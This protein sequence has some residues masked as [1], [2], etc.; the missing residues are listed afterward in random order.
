MC[1]V[2][3]QC[4][5]ECAVV[6]KVP[7]LHPFQPSHP[8]HTAS[9]KVVWVVLLQVAQRS[10][11]TGVGAGVSGGG[12]WGSVSVGDDNVVVNDVSCWVHSGSVDGGVDSG[13]ARARACVWWWQWSGCVWVG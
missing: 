4:S 7:A 12:A 8:V 1:G 13:G 3:L 2:G 9:A 10:L 6:R 5:P 11:S